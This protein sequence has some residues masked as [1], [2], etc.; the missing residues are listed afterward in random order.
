M[1][2]TF[3]LTSV[4]KGAASRP[5]PYTYSAEFADRPWEERKLA[6][7]RHSFFSGHTSLAAA[8]LFYGATSYALYADAP[9]P[10]LTAGMYGVA[11]GGTAWTGFTRVRA[12]KHFASDVITGGLVGAMLGNSAPVATVRIARLAGGD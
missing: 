1:G 4:M 8:S 7:H 12:G 5:R 6:D 2:G 3:V 10:A 11:L 9:D